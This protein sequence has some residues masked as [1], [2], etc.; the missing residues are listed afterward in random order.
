M[1][2]CPDCGKEIEISDTTYSNVNTNRAH[3]GEK[4]GDIYFCDVCEAHWID[5]YL[6]GKI[7]S[8]SY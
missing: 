8:W 5:D 6:D 2:N 3:D 7:R 4:T 1:I